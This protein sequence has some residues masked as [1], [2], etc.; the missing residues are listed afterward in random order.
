M[1]TKHWI[2]L[3]AGAAIGSVVAWLLLN[4][5]NAR[6]DRPPKGAPQIPLDNPGDQSEFSTSPGESEIG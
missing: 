1:K 2:L 4:E 5:R 3:G 6:E